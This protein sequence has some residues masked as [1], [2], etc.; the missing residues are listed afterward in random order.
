M[1]FVGRVAYTDIDYGD[2]E[3]GVSSN[4]DSITEDSSDEFTLDVGIRS[5]FMDNLEGTVGL[6]Y[7]TMDANSSRRDIDNT[8]VFG[9]ILFEASDTIDFVFSLDIGDEIDRYAIGIRFSPND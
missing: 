4:I 2:F 9:S 3:L 8:S 6:R 7:L 1:D 5:Q